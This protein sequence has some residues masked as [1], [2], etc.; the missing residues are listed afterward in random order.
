MFIGYLENY[1]N[2]SSRLQKISPSKNNSLT[3]QRDL[4]AN[5]QTHATD[6]Q[7]KNIQFS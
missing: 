1:L 6:L 7:I 5:I 4:N 3:D 2:K